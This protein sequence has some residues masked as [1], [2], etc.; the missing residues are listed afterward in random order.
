[1]LKI[2]T[3]GIVAAVLFAAGLFAGHSV[4]FAETSANGGNTQKPSAQSLQISSGPSRDT[5]VASPKLQ[6]GE[7]F[8]IA[9][10]PQQPIAVIAHTREASLVEF[11]TAEAPSQT[12]STA[13]RA[14]IRQLI[15]QL[16]PETEPDVAEIWT[17]TYADMDLDEVQFILEQK[18]RLSSG[19]QSFSSSASLF[20]SP[21]ITVNTDSTE[22]PGH[23]IEQIVQSNLRCSW[24]LGFRRTAVFP[25]VLSGTE[26]SKNQVDCFTSFRCFDTGPLVHSPIATHVALVDDRHL[27]FLLD[28]NTMTRRGDFRLLANRRLGVITSAGE[29][30]VSGSA[31]LP[32]SATNITILPNG[33]IRWTNVT[34]ETGEAGRVSIV[35]IDNLSQL[36]SADGVFFTTTDM[37]NVKTPD[38]TA[39]L[40][41]TNTLEQSNVDRSHDERL[42]YDLKSATATSAGTRLR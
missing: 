18:R 31:A 30:A 21:P 13:H 20:E 22:V 40:I 34:G 11:Q 12:A 3:C 33:L 17:D 16:V 23:D 6:S 5:S 25:E 38:E 7:D 9:E 28:D 29:R 41:L 39:T 26:T 1:M 37:T 27:M 15:E 32:D 8:E 19:S 10:T 42:L 35:Q 14:A 36:Q 2:M 24:S 4:P